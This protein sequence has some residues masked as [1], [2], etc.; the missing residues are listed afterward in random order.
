MT[1]MDI[2]PISYE[3]ASTKEIVSASDAEKKHKDDPNESFKP[4]CTKYVPTNDPNG[5]F[6]MTLTTDNSFVKSWT[7]R[8]SESNPVTCLNRKKREVLENILD[9][10]P[11]MDLPIDKINLYDYPTVY[12]NA[13]ESVGQ[14]RHNTRPVFVI[15]K[16]AFFRRYNDDWNFCIVYG[17]RLSR[18]SKYISWETDISYKALTEL[19]ALVNR[20]LTEAG[21]FIQNDRPDNS[22][23]YKQTLERLNSI[24]QK[25]VLELLKM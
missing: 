2:I 17:Y 8:P 14:D 15:G 6:T 24:T 25:E 11:Y 18:D 22:I 10:I 5:S 4:I 12:S 9:F 20:K 13:L 3:I 19:Y 16:V 1:E 7:H 23:I 21:L